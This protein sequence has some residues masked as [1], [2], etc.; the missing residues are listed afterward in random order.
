LTDLDQRLKKETEEIMAT[1]GEPS[2]RDLSEGY[3]ITIMHALL[4]S[5][6]PEHERTAL[7]IWREAMS[8]IGAGSETSANT[9][10][11]IHFH[12][13]DNPDT[14]VQLQEELREGLPDKEE[15]TL[16]VVEKLPYLVSF[17]S[18]TCIA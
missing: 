2:I 16:G 17:H 12:L 4:D 11:T 6:L 1:H 13:L 18:T 5:D 9:L 10:A 3:D 7:R 14:L 8:V 15:V